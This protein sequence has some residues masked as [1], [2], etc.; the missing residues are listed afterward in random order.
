MYM[1]N[2][3]IYQKVQEQQQA[4]STNDAETDD[5]VVDADYEDIK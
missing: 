2:L 5:N 1:N 3:Q 4:Q